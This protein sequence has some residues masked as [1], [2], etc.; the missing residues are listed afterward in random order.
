MPI[1]AIVTLLI[2]VLPSLIGDIAQVSAL[3]ETASAAVKN[4]QASADGL[5]AAADWQAM[6][7]ATQ[8]DLAQLALDAGL[9][10][11]PAV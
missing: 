4:A 9:T 7:A 5:V 8:A 1:A 10:P 6:V 2:Q 11:P 3:L